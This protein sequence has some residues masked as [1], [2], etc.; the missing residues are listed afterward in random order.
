MGQ[1]IFHGLDQ[2]LDQMKAIRYLLRLRCPAI[3]SLRIHPV[4]IVTPGCSCSHFLKEAAD[5]SGSRLATTPF[6]KSTRIVL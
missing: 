1:V 6:S 2:I 5:R 4:A 3:A